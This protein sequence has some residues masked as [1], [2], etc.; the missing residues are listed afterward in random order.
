MSKWGWQKWIGKLL[1]FVIALGALVW[2]LI[3]NEPGWWAVVVPA[4]TGFVQ[5]LLSL[6][7]EKP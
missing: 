1:W 4:A 5:W 6:F 7:P 3:E 2:Q